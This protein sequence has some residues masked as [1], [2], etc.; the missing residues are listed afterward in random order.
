MSKM[1][2]GF[3]ELP[4]RE[5]V[6]GAPR[7]TFQRAVADLLD[8]VEEL[9]EALRLMAHRVPWDDGERCWCAVQPFDDGSTK[10]WR[11]DTRCREIKELLDE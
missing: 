7:Q 2:G 3:G 4:L 10:E 1:F 8:E 9:R 6:I 11:H 5:A